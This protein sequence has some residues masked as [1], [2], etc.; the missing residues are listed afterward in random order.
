MPHTYSTLLAHL[1]FS[2]KLRDPWIQPNIEQRLYA[3]C[4]T[5]AHSE[6]GRIL[7]MNGM[8]DHVH[9]LISLKPIVA[10]ANFVR[11]IKANSSRFIHETFPDHQR[12]AWQPGYAIF[13]VSE[14]VAPKVTTYIDNQK[15][16]HGTMSFEDEFAELLSLH[17]VP[18]DRAYLFDDQGEPVPQHE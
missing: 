3:Y 17:N 10:P 5:V 11:A 8:P 9:L 7:A 1:V 15:S 13:S 12:F 18:F 14:S 16:R 2:T 4:A 6:H